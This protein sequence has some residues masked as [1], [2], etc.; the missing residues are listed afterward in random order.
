MADSTG[1]DYRDL[2]AR[3]REFIQDVHEYRPD[4]TIEAGSLI[5]GVMDY[6]T[7]EDLVGELDTAIAAPRR[8]AVE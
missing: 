1:I 6:Q 2:L 7:M 3:V 5:F 4:D 8:A